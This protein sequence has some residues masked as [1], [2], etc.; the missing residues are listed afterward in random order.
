MGLETD[1][2]QGYLILS[3]QGYKMIVVEYRLQ[4]RPQRPNNNGHLYSVIL[5]R[6]SSW[7]L[8]LF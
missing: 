3:S 6:Q 8:R 1:N 7:H 2:Q 5:V 4:S